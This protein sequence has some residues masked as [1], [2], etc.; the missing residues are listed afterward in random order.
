MRGLG[1]CAETSENVGVMQAVHVPS[2]NPPSGIRLL[3]AT[4]RPLMFRSGAPAAPIATCGTCFLVGYRS[5]VFVITAAHLVWEMDSRSVLISPTDGS[6]DWLPLSNGYRLIG[7]SEADPNE[8]DVIAYE[9]SL[10]G[11]PSR[12]MANMRILSLNSKGGRDWKPTSYVSQFFLFGYPRDQNEVNY[13]AGAVHISQTFIAGRYVGMTNMQPTIH[14]I[15]AM[16]P[17]E[18]PSFA[19][20][21]GSPVLSLETRVGSGPAVRFCGIAIMGTP[22][23]GRMNFVESEVISDLLDTIIGHAATF[24]HTTESQITSGEDL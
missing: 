13:D 23:S 11:L 20:F 24:G 15:A 19:G 2:S 9:V 1:H 8:Y 3:R 12:V 10:Q 5:R 22:E 4:A 18:L 16:N 14:G 6:S 17:L 7:E 21:S